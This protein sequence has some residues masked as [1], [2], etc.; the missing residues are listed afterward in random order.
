MYFD[1][2]FSSSFFAFLCSL[3]LTFLY[4]I[5]E[6]I[7]DPLNSNVVFPLDDFFRAF[8]FIFF[9]PTFLSIFFEVIVDPLNSNVVLPLNDFF[10]ARNNVVRFRF[11]TILM[12]F[13][14]HLLYRQL[15]IGWVF[16]P[17]RNQIYFAQLLLGNCLSVLLCIVIPFPNLYN[18]L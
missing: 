5:F 2:I 11:W 16:S 7:V 17:E 6:I 15:V 13:L 1:L 3:F 8:R 18:K 9:P 4:K 12:I 10:G 14:P